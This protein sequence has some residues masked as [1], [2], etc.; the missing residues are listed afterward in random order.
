MRPHRHTGE[1]HLSAG[2]PADATERIS[3][4][5]RAARND[6]D[7]AVIAARAGTGSGCCA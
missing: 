3:V 5:D 4:V 2:R 7:P 6:D 1:Q